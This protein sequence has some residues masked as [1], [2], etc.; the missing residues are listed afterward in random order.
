MKKDS[1]L[2]FFFP[3]AS[4]NSL[5]RHVV[6]NLGANFP[7]FLPYIILLSGWPLWTAKYFLALVLFSIAIFIPI[8]TLTAIVGLCYCC[9]IDNSSSRNFK[10]RAGNLTT[11]KKL[12]T[13]ENHCLSFFMYASNN[14]TKI[15]LGKR[16]HFTSE[17]NM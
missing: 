17:E 10:N 8:S 3:E 14:Y 1:F 4:D 15:C 11:V 16:V 12:L 6:G 9:A 13:P 5:N 2:F 7:H